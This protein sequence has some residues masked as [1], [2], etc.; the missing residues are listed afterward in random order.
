MA[1]RKIRKASQQE[2][3]GYPSLREHLI[4]RRR[5]L[6]VASVSLAAS[7]LVAACGRPLG[8]DLDESDGGTDPD[9]SHREV[10]A[11]IEMLGVMEEP[12]YFLLRIPETDDLAAYLID[13]GYCRFYVEVATYSADSYHALRDEILQAQDRCRNALSDFTYDT[14]D[15]A[16]GHAEAE[17]DLMETL[18]QLC[19]ELNN[20]TVPTIEGVTLTLTHLEPASEIDGGIGQPEYP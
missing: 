14:L 9:A 7:G 11:D 5:F 18:D 13:G 12:D 4:S 20:H 17:D 8:A 16:D 15:T 6:E 3:A 2:E 19:Q 10:D 1:P